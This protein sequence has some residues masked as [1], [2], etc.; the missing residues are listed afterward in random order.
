MKEKINNLHE[1]FECK[2]CNHPSK[3]TTFTPYE[4]KIGHKWLIVECQDCQATWKLE[5]SGVA[6]F[7]E[8][9]V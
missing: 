2:R 3:G 6:I 7:R 4:N 5:E 1:L 8:N 9:Q